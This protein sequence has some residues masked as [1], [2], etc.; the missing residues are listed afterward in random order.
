MGDKALTTLTDD[1]GA[2]H[3]DGMTSGVWTVAV[4]MFGFTT[5]RKE[6]TISATPSKIDFALTLR[7]RSQFGRG[8]GG[9]RGGTPA[10][11]ETEAPTIDMSATPEAASAGAGAGGADQSLIAQGSLSQ[12]LQTNAGD[13]QNGDFG[14]GGG[15]GRG[16]GGF[17]GPGG[18]GGPGGPGGPDRRPA[19][20]DAEAADLAAAEVDAA[21]AV[22]RVEDAADPVVAAGEVLAIATATRRL[23][24]TGLRPPTA[25]PDRCFIPSA[26]RL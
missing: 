1:Q 13:F 21:E 14:P 22:D 6:V 25:S 8:P 24:A 12:G 17:G 11:G 3:I 10:E 7:D 20:V 16:A 9:G 23:S 2:F 5:A 4:E 15:F 26:T 19:A 18:S